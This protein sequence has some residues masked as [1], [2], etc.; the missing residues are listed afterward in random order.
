MAMSIGVDVIGSDVG[1]PVM[2]NSN[3]G[4]P[5]AVPNGIV[6]GL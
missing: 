6:P 2:L 1:A 3:V 5:I 4:V